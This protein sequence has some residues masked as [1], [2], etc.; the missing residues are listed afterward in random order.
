MT[1]F[2]SNGKLLLSAEY[3]VLDRALAL[4]LPTKYGQSLSVEKIEA[5][6]SIWESYDN[7]GS[8][9]L[10][11][12]FTLSDFDIISE[13]TSTLGDKKIVQLQKILRTTRQMNS[14]FLSGNQN[15]KIQTKLSFSRQWGLGSSSTLINNMAQ[16]A[17][18]D[19]FEL[20]F[21]CFGGSAYDVACA[22]NNSSILYQLKNQKPIVKSVKFNPDFKD[23]LYFVYLNQKQN[24]RDGIQLYQNLKGDVK[25]AVLEVSEI[26][27]SMLNCTKLSDFEILINQH[28]KIISKLIQTKPI[29]E[30]LFS[31]YFGSIKSLGAWGGDFIL[32]TGNAETPNYFKNKGFNTVIPFTKMVL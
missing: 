20:Q 13:E 22:Q 25:N 10:S 28:E 3:L 18:V 30:Q 4:A 19:A 9:W 24:S 8:L 12:K 1:Q 6:H 23:Q 21:K 16:W 31:D 5:S 29:K 32:A 15:Y 27:K 7:D 2:Y 26:S 11:I 17:Q 14:S